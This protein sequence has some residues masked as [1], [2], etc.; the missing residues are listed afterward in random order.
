MTDRQADRWDRLADREIEDF[1]EAARER[2]ETLRALR[3]ESPI[4]ADFLCAFLSGRHRCQ[5]FDPDYP[6]GPPVVCVGD[7]VEWYDI[8]PQFKIGRYRVDFL[9]EQTVPWLPMGLGVAGRVVV[10]CDGHDFH[11][12]TKEQA[13][14]DRARDRHLQQQGLVV[15]R[16]TGSEIFQDAA[17]CV[18]ETVAALHRVTRDAE[19]S[20]RTE[21]ELASLK[22]RT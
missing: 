4:E 8:R 5:V 12:R 15:L 1:T 6:D 16:F 18:K 21:A 3:I 13:K 9:I 7:D 2:A 14:R 10:E 11:E 19:R 17:A 22:T 20:L